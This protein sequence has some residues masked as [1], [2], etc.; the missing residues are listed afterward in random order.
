[1]QKIINIYSWQTTYKKPIQ[2]KTSA[3]KQRSW[4]N[5]IVERNFTD[6]FLNH[7]KNYNKARLLATS[8]KHSADW[9][10]TLLITSCGLRLDNEAVRVAVS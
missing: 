10:N 8:V 5:Q 3:A 2:S 7:T 9:L 6:L 4:N 1:M